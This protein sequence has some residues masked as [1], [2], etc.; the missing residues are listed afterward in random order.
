MPRGCV[1]WPTGGVRIGG[2]MFGESCSAVV[3]CLPFL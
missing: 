3:F 2:L 1:F